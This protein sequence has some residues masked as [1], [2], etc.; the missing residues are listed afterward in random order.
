M[1]WDPDIYNKFKTERYAPFY[2]LLNLCH[3]KPGIK[4]IDLGCGTGELT[5]K[6]AEYLTGADLTGIDSSKEMLNKAAAFENNRLKFICRPIQDQIKEGTKWDLIFSNAALQWIDDHNRL[7]NDL[8][9]LLNKGG[10]LAIQVPSN[11]DHFTHVFLQEL[12]VREPYKYALT[13]WERSSPVL[14]IN[15]YANI[16]FQNGATEN[17]VFEKVYTHILKNS[18]GMF[19]WVSGTALIPYLE[20]L[21]EELK[22]PFKNDYRKGLAGR[23]KD[24]PLFYPFKRILMK[25]SFES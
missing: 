23:F 5:Q 14:T 18:D 16:F 6:L 8:I 19:D 25:A 20:R 3:N 9:R 2:D 24:S 4:G 21:P 7:I 17:I 12:A 10:Q 22:E 15:E 11:H 1:T 13:G